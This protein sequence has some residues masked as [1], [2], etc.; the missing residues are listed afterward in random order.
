M[1]HDFLKQTKML[2]RDIKHETFEK[3]CAV[4]IKKTYIYFR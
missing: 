2:M 4:S 3:E 1:E